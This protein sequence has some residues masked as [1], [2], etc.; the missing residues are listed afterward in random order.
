MLAEF[1]G[2]AFLVLIGCGAWTQSTNQDH[3]DAVKIALAFGFTYTV[4]VYC[5]KSLGDCHISSSVTVALLATRRCSVIKALLYLFCQLFGAILGA[6]FVFGVTSHEQRN[7]TAHRIGC[8]VPA[9][10]VPESHAFGVEFFAT[11]FLV[12]VVFACYEK[13]PPEETSIP[14]PVAPLLIGITYAA[15][16][17]FAVPYSGASMNPSRSFGP[18]LIGGVW[19]KHWIYWFGP[20]FGGILGAALH[21]LIFSAKASFER[22]KSCLLVHKGESSGAANRAAQHGLDGEEHVESGL[23]PRAEN[24]ENEEQQLRLMKPGLV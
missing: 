24:R 18:A 12:F 22:L 10:N 3:P 15:V 1:I 9:E 11:F 4:V 20:I 2:S 14:E 7:M 16:T 23:N 17:L 13:R 19:T 8:T 21:E 5:F 6:C